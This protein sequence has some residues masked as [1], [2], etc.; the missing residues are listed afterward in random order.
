MADECPFCNERTLSW[1]DFG[2]FQGDC[3]GS[4]VCISCGGV[5]DENNLTAD[6]GI[7]NSGQAGS[8]GYVQATAK[9]R[10]Q[11]NVR[12]GAPSMSKG[13][14]L[15]LD[16]TKRIARCMDC[17][18]SMTAEAVELFER[19][20]GHP[21]FRL[22]RIVAKLAVAA[23]CVYIICRQHNWPVMLADV[24]GMVGKSV[25]AVDSWKKRI[26]ATF[27]DLAHVRAPDLF[28]L[29]SARCEKAVV[30]NEVQQTAVAIIKLSRDLWIAEGRKQ[31][32]IIIPALFIAWQGE[33]PACRIKVKLRNFCRD[34]QL[35]AAYSTISCL[36]NM[37]Q[38][39]CRLAEKIPWLTASSVT[40]ATVA[41]HVKDIINYR[42]TLIAEARSE[43]LRIQSAID[44]S[45]AHTGNGNSDSDVA[46]KSSASTPG[47]SSFNA[48]D[49]NFTSSVTVN[50]D[51]L[52]SSDAGFSHCVATISEKES[53]VTSNGQT[54][55]RQH[56][57]YYDSFW[58][59]P[60]YKPYTKYKKSSELAVN[61]PDL[62]CAHLSAH[63]IPDE[64]MHLY[65]KSELL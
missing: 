11:Y 35:P 51:V 49:T 46:C 17:K 14:R 23:C 1:E 30:S 41:V 16:L 5:V 10:Q 55:K 19:L 54:V 47:V 18:P 43:I 32:N 57:D 22:R 21:N 8:D 3:A 15:G 53:S 50:S 48:D 27:P 26:M 29:L 56:A 42:T 63:D 64:D 36:G 58:P 59:P 40:D 25:H 9:E 62:D 6:E 13:R 33:E 37:Q 31:D 44:Y 61:H 45:T 12:C 39:L 20:V 52:T 34:R 24:C 65:I 4:R 60:G 28:Q 38:T 7:R 2:N